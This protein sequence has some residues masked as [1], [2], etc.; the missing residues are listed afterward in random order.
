[1]SAALR[2]RIKNTTAST[3]GTPS[4]GTSSRRVLS[5]ASRVNDDVP[6]VS[7]I[8]ESMSSS[9]GH[10]T[11][12]S[13]TSAGLIRPEVERQA[14]FWSDTVIDRHIGMPSAPM[15]RRDLWG[16]SVAE[17]GNNPGGLGGVGRGD[18]LAHQRVDQRGL[19]GLERA[20]Q[21]DA[22]GFI[23]AR[24]DAIQFVEDIL[25]LLIRRLAPVGL[26]GSA[27]NRAD[28]IACAHA[29]LTPFEDPR[30]L[31]TCRRCRRPVSGYPTAARVRGLCCR[32]RSPRC[33]RR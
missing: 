10:S 3:R 8:V 7:M 2:V 30:R 13:T 19:S 18:V 5:E 14:A 17:P 31:P 25:P 33:V 32:G 15:V 9:A 29:R 1:M 16:G 22:D 24:A 28:L 11:S 21:R 12:R 27:Q 4:G 6:G 20:G 26:N 23:E